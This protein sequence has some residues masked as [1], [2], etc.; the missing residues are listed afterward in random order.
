MSAPESFGDCPDRQV[1][2]FFCRPE[3]PGPVQI[4]KGNI[5]AVMSRRRSVGTRPPASMG[6]LHPYDDGETIFGVVPVADFLIARVRSYSWREAFFH[7]AQLSAT[8]ARHGKSSEIVRRL[9]VDPLARLT[10]DASAASII[11]NARRVVTERRN[12]VVLAHEEAISFLQHLVLLEGGDEEGENPGDSEISLWLAGAGSHLGKWKYEE[13]GASAREELIASLAHNLRF[14]NRPDPARLL[15]RAR[16]MFSRPPDAGS[17]ATA[18]SWE[19]L[20]EEAFGSTYEEFFESCLGPA[21]LLSR[22]WGDAD[23]KWSRP[24]LDLATLLKETKLSRGSFV[25]FLDKIS[26]DRDT[27]REAI[28]ERV[29]ADGLP[30]APTSLLYRPFLRNGDVFI[31]ASP[32]AVDQQLRGGV[33]S[34]FLEAAKRLPKKKGADEWFRAFGNILEHWCRRIATEASTSARFSATVH[35]PAK[36]GDESEIE[37]VVLIEDGAAVL[38]S[39]KGRMM[40]AEAGRE[41]VSVATTMKWYEDFFFEEKGDDYRGGAIQLLQKRIRRIRAGEFESEGVACTVELWPIVVTYDALGETP[42]LYR[43][44]E[45]QCKSRGLLQDAG[46][47]SV[48]LA[49]VDEFEDLMSRVAAGR[50]L[51]RLLRRRQRIDRYRRLD[52]TLSENLLPKEVRRLDYFNREHEVI[53]DRIRVRLFG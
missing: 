1:R 52:Q 10:G 11:A 2:E 8:V 50:S 28:R 6:L 7:L 48:T 37:D 34:L 13:P 46:V 36:P 47:R 21:F 17:L 24:L 33:W 3:D 29:R 49:R 32:W 42:L 26:A 35:M 5:L 27:H 15:V 23:G 19:Q 43:W 9:T 38:F 14:N 20:A 22:L 40:R 16:R 4:G 41:A 45:E 30:H 31:G 44:L 25:G 18:E 51:V 53:A 12:D 39:V